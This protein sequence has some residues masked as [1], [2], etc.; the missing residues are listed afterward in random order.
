MVIPFLLVAVIAAV[1]IM[2]WQWYV[3]Q[4]SVAVRLTQPGARESAQTSG[5]PELSSQNWFA[6]WLFRAGFRKPEAP[7]VFWGLTIL[8]AVIGLIL[9]YVLA[10]QGLF[11]IAAET[12]SAIPGGVG[13]VMIPFVLG[14]P[15]IFWFVLILTPALI[16]R[17][18]RQNRVKS[19]ERELPLL[20]DLLNTLAQAGIGFDSALDQILSVQDPSR[21]LVQE[22]RLFQFDNLAGRSRIESL[23]RLMRRVHVPLFSSFISAI[24]QAEQ[25]GSG[26]GQTL[27]TQ[28]A[29]M[30]ARRR[31]KAA[32]AAM[33][34]P[35]KLV[36]P[37]VVG[38]LPGIF[39]VLLGPLLFEAFGAL[40]QSVTGPLGR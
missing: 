13:N 15:W 29:E 26:M 23:R 10:Q 24:V 12:V 9:M 7:L 25:T 35:T 19:I 40:G 6:N 36:V 1:V 20:L 5:L 3:V 39:V 38:F 4:S 28:S 14:A 17:S 8:L 30:R 21:P 16:V 32:A 33:M 11:L 18:V 31:E 34:V 27:R 37:M 22:L 2:L